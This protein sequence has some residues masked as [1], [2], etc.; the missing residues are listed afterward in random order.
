MLSINVATS[1]FFPK[2]LKSSVISSFFHYWL[3]FWDIFFTIFILSFLPC[4]LP[5]VLLSPFQFYF[6]FPS[7][8]VWMILSNYIKHRN[9][10]WEKMHNVSCSGTGLINLMWLSPVVFICL[11]MKSHHSS[12]LKKLIV[13]LFSFYKVYVSEYKSHMHMV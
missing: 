9:Y 2:W 3:T 12:F 7:I 6:N 13:Q 10:K 11:Q 4:F 5:F 1:G 8:Y